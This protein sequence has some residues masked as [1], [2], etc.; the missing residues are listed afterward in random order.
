M[1]LGEEHY[2][3]YHI[4]NNLKDYVCQGLDQDKTLSSVAG[5]K[6]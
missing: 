1:E 6:L 5:H 3:K 4:I 2:V